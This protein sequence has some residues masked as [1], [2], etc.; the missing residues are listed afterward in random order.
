MRMK[1]KVQELGEFIRSQRAGAQMSLRKLAKLAGVSNPYL[2][3]VE[4][5][6]RRPSAEILSAIAKGLRVSSQTLYVK[7]GILEEEPHPDVHTAVMADHILSEQQKQALLQV[8]DSFRE[9]T[10]R[11]RRN[12]K[13]SP[14]RPASSKKA[15]VNGTVGTA[16]R[17]PSRRSSKLGG[18]TE[19]Q[20]DPSPHPAPLRPSAAHV[21]RTASTAKTR[22]EVHR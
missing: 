14:R 7:A 16:R 5:G 20:A 10:G 4:R 6:L 22:K 12:G 11:T 1:P 9:E 17:A 21:R 3:Q 13:T 15:K 18:G 19:M 8:Y 2:S